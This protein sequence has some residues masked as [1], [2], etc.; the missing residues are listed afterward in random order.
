MDY[1]GYSTGMGTEKDPGAALP[2]LETACER[3]VGQACHNLGKI[4]IL[5]FLTGIRSELYLACIKI[6]V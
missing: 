1:P 4:K 2:I 3:G 6:I 5:S